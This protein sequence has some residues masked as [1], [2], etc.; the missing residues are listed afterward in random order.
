[1]LRFVNKNEL[2]AEIDNGIL[3]LL[4]RQTTWTLKSVQDVMALSLMKDL[5]GKRIAEV[6]GGNSRVLEV[7]KQNNSCVNVDE[8]KGVGKGPT[9]KI[10]INGVENIYANMGAFSPSLGDETFDVIFSISVIEHVPSDQLEVF[11]EDSFRIL[12]PGG[13]IIHLIDAYV[14]DSVSRNDALKER[15]SLFDKYMTNDAVEYSGG[16][17]VVAPLKFS[18]SY[19]TNPDEAMVEWNRIAPTLRSMRETAQ[20]CTLLLTGLKK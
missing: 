4:P 14:G 17:V 20:S 10:E 1:M 5:K 6:G 2:W 7:L 3:E 11:F 12:K 16:E 15:I 9:K 19:A 18:C 8:F 13:Q